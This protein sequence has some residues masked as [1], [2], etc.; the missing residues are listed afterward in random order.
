MSG[1]ITDPA[2]Y[3]KVQNAIAEALGLDDDE[4]EA[5]ALL[6]EDLGAESL[7]FLDIVFR[8]ERAFDIKIPR[9]GIEAQAKD[10][11]GDTGEYEV[12]GVL[13]ELGLKRLAEAMPEVPAEDFKP[14][15]KSSEI[16]TLF[17]VATFYRLVVNL[18]EEK[19]A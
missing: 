18:L 6:M 14:G 15:L 12:D 19:G 1:I 17:R 7:D 4:V 3:A 8:L 16:P 13:T 2:I 5:D 10:E 11:L 9:G